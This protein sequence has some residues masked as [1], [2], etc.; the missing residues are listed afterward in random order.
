MAKKIRVFNLQKIIEENTKA[1]PGM[2]DI[3]WEVVGAKEVG[4]LK[5]PKGMLMIEGDGVHRKY[6]H[7]TD[8]Y[9][10]SVAPHEEGS[11]QVIPTHVI[12]MG[13]LRFEELTFPSEEK[14]LSEFVRKFSARIEGNY[15]TLLKSIEEIG[16]NPED[17]PREE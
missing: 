3:G 5:G 4:F 7:S 11:M 17:F 16:L 9:D 6:A 13:I 1:A 2:E 8:T 14:T 15:E 10:V 12:P